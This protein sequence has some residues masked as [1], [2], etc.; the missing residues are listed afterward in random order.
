MNGS[1][2]MKTQPPVCEPRLAGW[3]SKG[4]SSTP[5]TV[6]HIIDWHLDDN[7]GR[8]VIEVSFCVFLRLIRTAMFLPFPLENS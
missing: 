8:E 1:F 6:C 2:E 5:T 4:L 3:G 7:T